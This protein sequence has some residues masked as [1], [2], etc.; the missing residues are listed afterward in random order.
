VLNTIK[1]VKNVEL[2]IIGDGEKK[3]KL[4]QTLDN[5]NIYYVDHGRVFSFEKKFEIANNCKFA[6]NIM[7]PTVKVGLTMKSIEY[8]QFGLPLLN[9]IKADTYEIVEKY[10]VGYNV[11]DNFNKLEKILNLTDHEHL[12]MRERSR[13]VYEKLFSEKSFQEKVKKILLK[14]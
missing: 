14:Y 9:N 5:N 12:L 3:Q 6:I 10:N 11:T 1:C 13:I 7:K 8:F 2:H 4:L